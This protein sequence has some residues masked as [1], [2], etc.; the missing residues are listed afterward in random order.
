V[1]ELAPGRARWIGMS[2]GGRLRLEL[3]AR[4][5]QRIERAVL[6]EPV[7]Q[8]P[9]HVGADMAAWTTQAPNESEVGGELH[10]YSRD[11]TVAVM[12]EL[13]RTLPA[14]SAAPALLVVADGSYL[15]SGVWAEEL[16]RGID[17]LEVVH[18]PG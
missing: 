12:G 15:P 4:E 16:Q 11:A 5:P 8:L 9:E 6:L 10:R 7:L 3:A 14:L 17:G 18:V 13:T 1:L 2:F